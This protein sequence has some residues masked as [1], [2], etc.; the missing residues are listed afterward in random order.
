M[1]EIKYKTVRYD[2]MVKSPPAYRNCKEAYKE[3]IK[4][5]HIVWIKIGSRR[6][7]K[8]LCEPIFKRSEEL[9]PIIYRT[10]IYWY[11][12]EEV[13]ILF[14]WVFVAFLI[15]LVIFYFVL[16]KK[17]KIKKNTKSS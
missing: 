4:D 14:S 5:K 15:I 16:K 1:K 13:A 7:E 17:W 2:K 6:D 3:M 12:K 8:S 10:K 9:N 11:T